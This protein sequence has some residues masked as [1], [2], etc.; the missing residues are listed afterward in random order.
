M[1]FVHILA[2]VLL[3]VNYS[4]AAMCQIKDEKTLAKS[5][6]EIVSQWSAKQNQNCAVVV[7]TGY[8]DLD[9]GKCK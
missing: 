7:A 6:V 4:Y 1:I 5:A 9:L 2:A 3:L 8:T